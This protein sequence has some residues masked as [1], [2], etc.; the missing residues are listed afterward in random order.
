MGMRNWPIR[1]QGFGTCAPRSVVL[2]LYSCP[3]NV[4]NPAL[5]GT[6][7]AVNRGW[8]VKRE[9]D[10]EEKAAR[11]ERTRPDPGASVYLVHARIGIHPRE[12]CLSHSLFCRP[13]TGRG[14]G[15][16]GAG[17]LAK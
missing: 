15:A 12:R 2:L 14:V 4:R 3:R 11:L 1:V 6:G 5:L 16:L 8:Y 13:V 9:Q 10:V 7:L 17:S